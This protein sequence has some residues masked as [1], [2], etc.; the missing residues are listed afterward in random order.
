MFIPEP[1]HR[2]EDHQ[3]TVDSEEEFNA[4]ATEIARKYGDPLLFQDIHN[5]AKVMNIANVSE[6]LQAL[7][8]YIRDMKTD[9]ICNFLLNPYLLSTT[10]FFIGNMMFAFVL[11]FEDKL[12]KNTKFTIVVTGAVCDCIAQITHIYLAINPWRIKYKKVQK[13]SKDVH[14]ITHQ[15][16]RKISQTLRRG[17][18]SSANVNL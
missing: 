13:F 2:V 17:T 16:S 3:S 4:I 6:I 1:E 5:E 15:T 11:F 14:K 18:V 7:D 10:I 12:A 9:L 8:S